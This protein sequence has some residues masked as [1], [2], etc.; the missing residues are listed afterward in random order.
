MGY[1]SFEN[2]IDIN[3]KNFSAGWFPGKEHNDIPG[4]LT[5]PDYPL[6]SPDCNACIWTEGSLRKFFGYND[7]TTSILTGYV[8]SLFYSTIL[9]EFVGTIGTGI[10]SDMHQAT[11]TDIT[12]AITVS[13][14]SRPHWA[15]WQFETNHYVIGV[16]GLNPPWKWTGSGNCSVLAGSPPQG[17]WVAIWQSSCWIGRTASEP[18]TIYFSDPADPETWTVD[19]DYKFDAPITGIG[20]L[21]DKLVVF[22]ENSIGVLAGD[23]NDALTK[24]DKY[25]SGVGC[26]SGHSI[27]NSKVEGE[28]VLIFHSKDGYYAF[29]GTTTLMKI[30]HQISKKYISTD[31]WAT[32]LF[33]EITSVYWPEYNWYISN[34]ADGSDSYNNFQLVFDC[35]QMLGKNAYG[36]YVTGV[37]FLPCWP[38][39]DIPAIS[40]EIYDGALYFGSVDSKVYKFDVSNFNLNGSTYDAYFKSKIFDV[41]QEWTFLEANVMADEQNATINVYINADLEAGSGSMDVADVYDDSAVLGSTFIIGTSILGGKDFVNAH[42][43]VDVFGQYLQFKLQNNTVDKYFAIEEFQIMLQGLGVD[44]NKEDE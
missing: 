13:S 33:D 17:K 43:D 42:V 29:N 9:S 28:D 18:S 26:T 27:K 36:S 20:V 16:D 6:G 19:R 41:G 37:S 1:E 8:T 2:I 32:T 11:P 38:F 35:S 15:E 5:K 7:I 4:E 44:S 30:S 3:F 40:M 34:L 25:I 14:T 23:N 21:G 10:Y 22:K 12:G 39:D 24:V 31:K